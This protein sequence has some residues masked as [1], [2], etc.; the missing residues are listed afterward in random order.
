M[1]S[2]NSISLLAEADFRQREHNRQHHTDHREKHTNVEHERRT[3]GTSTRCA[4]MKGCPETR[5]GSPLV[6]A[7]S[8]PTPSSVAGLKTSARRP[9]STPKGDRYSTN[10]DT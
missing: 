4:V 9:A 8:R 2:T 7:T 1:A 6:S 3:N 10:E 5:A